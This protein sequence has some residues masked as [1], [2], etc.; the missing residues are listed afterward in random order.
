LG[1]AE[2]QV[3]LTSGFIGPNKGIEYA[4]RAVELAAPSYPRLLYVIV[5][6]P[7]PEDAIAQEYARRLAETIARSSYRDHIL[8]VNRH[9]TDDE[10]A[11]WVAAADIC[12]LPYVEPEQVSSGVLARYLGMGRAIVST[13]FTYAVEVLEDGRG[14]LVPMRDELALMAAID[15][16]LS[17]ADSIGRLQRAALGAGRTMAWSEVAR[18]H[19]V[20]VRSALKDGGQ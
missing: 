5:G 14:C 1:V 16:L 4:L 3:L 8:W 2:R 19:A 9:V 7:H 12:V 15:K 13:D 18:L 6:Q 17:D 11:R 10:L 20:T